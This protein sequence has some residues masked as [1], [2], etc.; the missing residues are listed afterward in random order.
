MN[1]QSSKLTG[2]LAV[3]LV[4]CAAFGA[5]WV[6]LSPDQAE[7]F[8]EIV[9]GEVKFS[10]PKI[11]RQK[12]L[13]IKPLYDD[14]EVV[15]DEEL[16]AVL[17]Q[18]QPQFSPD[19]LRPNHVE[20][21]LRTWHVDAE[22]QDPSI[23]SGTDMRDLLLDHGRFLLSWGPDV[24]PLLEDRPTGVYVRWGHDR[25]ASVHH[26][27]TLACLSEAGVPLDQ[28][29]RSP[30]RPNGTLK[31]MIEQAIYD[32]DLD[33][34]ETEW[35]A[36]GFGLWIAPQKEWVNG[37]H[38][39]LNFDMIARRQMRGHKTYGVCGG[40]HRVYSLMSLVRLDDE[41]DILSDEVHDEAM[42]YLASVRDIL[43]V[44]Q[45][46]DGHW[47][48]NWPDGEAALESPEGYDAYKDVIAT[49]HHLEW[50]AIAPK[51][52]H[53]PHE[54]ILKAADWII[55]NTTSKTKKEI[56]SNY[57]FYSHVGNALALWRNTRAPAFW[58]K[59]EAKHPF[60]A[61]TDEVA[62][63]DTAE[64]ATDEAVT[65]TPSK[66][67][68]TEEVETVTGKEAP[69]EAETDVEPKPLIVPPEL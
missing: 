45:F 47:P 48:Y 28:P 20:H 30:G 56:L 54:Q 22:F 2:F 55:K 33:E 41:F 40:T 7:Q 27:H 19:N 39:K 31:Q 32:F 13:V 66:E 16:A 35:S 18:V 69:A 4:T 23:M 37:H 50:L 12:P 11:E 63:N 38:R 15:S 5:G 67:E 42:K 36:M 49:G 57:T 34:R 3:Q 8:T 17:I 51:E 9:T 10:P 21:A 43:M 68:V 6:A 65:D 53:P 62:V 14:P 61:E 1:K 58:K 26:D 52:L 29:V 25:G 44:T 64:A 59:W 46:E 60:K 24:E